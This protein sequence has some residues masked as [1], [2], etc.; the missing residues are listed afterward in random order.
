MAFS[1]GGDRRR[2]SV[3]AG[4]GGGVRGGTAGPARRAVEPDLDPGPA[5]RRVRMGRGSRRNRGRRQ[6]GGAG[7][8][9][10][11]RVMMRV[12]EHSST[13][14]CRAPGTFRAGT[15][16]D[17]P[18]FIRTCVWDRVFGMCLGVLQGHRT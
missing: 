18:D 7:R 2:R 14:Q 13:V 17:D 6:R 10:D 15:Q 9:R 1:G 4:A 3:T 12:H 8:R 5:C 11:F 16:R